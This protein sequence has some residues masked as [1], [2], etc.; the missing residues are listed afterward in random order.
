L[1]GKDRTGSGKTLSYALPLTER[2][3]NQK[4]FQ[5]KRGFVILL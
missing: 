1:I 4:F 2:F 5:N 3:R